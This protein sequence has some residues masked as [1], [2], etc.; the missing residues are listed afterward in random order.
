M[1]WRMW[2]LLALPVGGRAVVQE[3]TTLLALLSANAVSLSRSFVTLF[4]PE[5]YDACVCVVGALN[6]ESL[7]A[8]GKDFAPD[9]THHLRTLLRRVYSKEETGKRVEVSAATTCYPRVPFVSR[10]PRFCSHR[11]C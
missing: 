4:V 5:L 11:P 2:I 1:Y 8:L 6:E 7:R 9:I 3:L 10:R